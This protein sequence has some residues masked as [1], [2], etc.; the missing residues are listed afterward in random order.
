MKSVLIIV[1]LILIVL[2]LSLLS[3]CTPTNITKPWVGQNKHEVIHS[4]GQPTRIESDG[5]GGEILVYYVEHTRE[6][7]GDWYPNGEG[8]FEL[9]LPT[10]VTNAESRMFYVDSNGI[11]Y[12]VRR[13]DFK[14]K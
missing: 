2:V 8:G 11:I 10:R 14:V 5:K 12:S 1:R 7:T 4:L 13:N 3:N 9:S 6:I